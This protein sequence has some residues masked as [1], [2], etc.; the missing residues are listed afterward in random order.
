MENIYAP[1]RSQY[2][3]NSKEGCV[4]CEISQ[5][6]Q[7]DEKNAVF[8][9]DSLC[10]GVMNR[11]PYTP[12]HLLFIPH[13]HQDSPE[14]FSEKTWLHLHKI[15]HKAIPMLYEYGAQGINFGIN[16]K[17]AGGAGIPEHLHLH[18]LPR[19]N[20]DTNFITSIM[21]SRIYGVDFFKTY[22]KIKLLAQKYLYKEV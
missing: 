3:E 21:D 5:N 6:T 17:K 16:I 1:W 13:I 11:F 15:I 18:L 7:D 14:K 10:Y 19:Y 22:Q 12:A 20:G 9:R 4:F 8:Y 2:F